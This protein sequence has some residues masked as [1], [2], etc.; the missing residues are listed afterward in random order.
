MYEGRV[1]CGFCKPAPSTAERADLIAALKEAA[2]FIHAVNTGSEPVTRYPLADELEGFAAFL[3]STPDHIPDAGKMVAAMPVG[4]LTTCNCLWNGE[5]QV[6]SCTLHEAH[7]DAIHE[8]AERAKTAESALLQSPALPDLQLCK[9]YGV[10]TYPDLVANMARHIE[11]L[12][13]KLP[14]TRDEQPGNAR[15][16]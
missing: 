1:P 12:Q 16:A 7:V 6:Q 4:E 5:K 15:F 10:E 11:K 13:A 9:F 2:A 14:P 3:Q 8:W